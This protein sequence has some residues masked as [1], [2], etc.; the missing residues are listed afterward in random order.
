MKLIILSILSFLFDM[1]KGFT[2][3]LRLQHLQCP[4]NIKTNYLSLNIKFFEG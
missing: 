3:I 1:L 2:L 4:V